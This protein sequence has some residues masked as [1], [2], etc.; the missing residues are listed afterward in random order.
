MSLNN[1]KST[2]PNY[3]F[4]IFICY[5]IKINNLAILFEFDYMK[6]WKLPY[7]YKY[8]GANP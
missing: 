5:K 7:E 3:V 8:I 2:G 4:E 6:Q 1:I